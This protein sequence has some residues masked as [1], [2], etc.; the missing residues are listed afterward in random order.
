MVDWYTGYNDSIKKYDFKA[1]ACMMHI[2]REFVEAV[3]AGSEKVYATRILRYIGQL[4]RLERFT[5]QIKLHR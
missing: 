2:R 3:D 4:Y 5:S 1:M